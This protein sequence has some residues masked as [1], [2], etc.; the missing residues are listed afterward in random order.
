MHG[1]FAGARGRPALAR[2]SGVTCSIFCCISIGSWVWA[3]ALAQEY[4]RIQVVRRKVEPNIAR[5]I[6]TSCYKRRSA[7]GPNRAPLDRRFESALY[8]AGRGADPDCTL[9]TDEI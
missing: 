1:C 6:N 7:A 3:F 2:A 9:V 8:D 5:R 4:A